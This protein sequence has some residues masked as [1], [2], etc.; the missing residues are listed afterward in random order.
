MLFT[1]T[2][3]WLWDLS[4]PV[5]TQLPAAI[6]AL[7]TV[8]AHKQLL[9]S[10][11]P[12]HSWVERVHI[13]VK[14]FAQWYSAI[15][16]QSIPVL[17]T[18]LSKVTGRSHHVTTPCMYMEYIIRYIRTLWLVTARELVL[19]GSF[20]SR[21]MSVRRHRQLW[22]HASHERYTVSN[23]KGWELNFHKPLPQRVSNLGPPAWQ[24]RTRHHCVI[25]PFF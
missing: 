5:P 19:S 7:E 24:A 9:S 8:Q 12:A 23:V 15:L 20:T 21:S 11:V 6:R 22:S 14:W 17:E 13:Q 18:S 3:T 1:S 10:Q 2:F 16:R 4:V 25:A